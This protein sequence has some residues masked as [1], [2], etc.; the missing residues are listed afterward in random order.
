MQSCIHGRRLNTGMNTAR[1]S[2]D[3]W[4]TLVPGTRNDAIELR[5]SGAFREPFPT[6]D[7]DCI[8]VMKADKIREM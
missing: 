6:W 4:N 5:N 7:C 1:H 3:R 8:V 2:I